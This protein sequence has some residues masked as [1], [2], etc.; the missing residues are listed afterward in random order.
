MRDRGLPE[1]V[2]LGA[3]D[4]ISIPEG[5]QPRTL[6]ALKFLGLV[7]EDDQR[8]PLFDRL[9]RA[10]TEEYREILAEVIRAAYAPVFELRDPAE[11][12][13][14]RITDA[15]RPYQ[16]ARQRERMVTLFMALCAEAGIVTEGQ[17]RA[18]RTTPRAQTRRQQQS[19]PA[20]TRG[21]GESSQG[22]D[23]GLDLR[24]VHATVDQLPAEGWWTAELRQRWVRA[25]EAQVDF[26]IEVR[27]EQP[28]RYAGEE[29]PSE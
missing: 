12:S 3:L 20:R 9:G 1:T 24:A 21:G 11:D 15:F 6:A 17:A 10:P 23:G 14:D 4:A 26:V 5:N 29:E 28:E 13:I 7:A 18:P 27:D 2:G 25:L 22:T 8:T 16:P 19:Q